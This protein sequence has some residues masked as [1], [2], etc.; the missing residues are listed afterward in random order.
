MPGD[1]DPTTV[2]TDETMPVRG[3][4]AKPVRKFTWK[5]LSK[6]NEPHNAHIAV[7]GKVYIQVG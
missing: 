4:E 1:G 6:L 2:V 7:G 5:E 3:D